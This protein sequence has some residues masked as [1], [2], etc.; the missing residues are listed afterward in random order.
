MLTVKS[1]IVHP[2][3]PILC[4]CVRT[5]VYVYLSYRLGVYT[6]KLVYDFSFV[7]SLF[8]ACMKVSS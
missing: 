8:L 7:L 5:C 1:W 2:L 3:I 4:G 6:I